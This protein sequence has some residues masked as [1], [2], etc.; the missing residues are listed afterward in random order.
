MYIGSLLTSPALGN[1]YQGMVGG[2]DVSF[3]SSPHAVEQYVIAVL[4]VR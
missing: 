4:Y 2:L 3:E 1:C